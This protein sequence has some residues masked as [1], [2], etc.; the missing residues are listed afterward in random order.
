MSFLIIDPS[1]FLLSGAS[2]AAV[3]AAIL[4]QD[5]ENPWREAGVRLT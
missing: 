2:V 1:P 5:A 3:G 4:G